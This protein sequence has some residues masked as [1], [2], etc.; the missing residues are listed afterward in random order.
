MSSGGV[1][2]LIEDRKALDDL[3]QKSMGNFARDVKRDN[4]P[5]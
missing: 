2:Y 4:M 5:T 1:P 3:R